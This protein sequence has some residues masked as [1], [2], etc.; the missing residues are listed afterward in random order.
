MIARIRQLVREHWSVLPN[1]GEKL[2]ESQL[3][4][5]KFCQRIVGHNTKILFLVTHASRTVCI[6]KIMRNTS[7]DWMLHREADAQRTLSSHHIVPQ[8]FFDNAVGQYLYAEEVIE[9]TPISTSVARR[10]APEII[11]SL[12]SLPRHQRVSAAEIAAVFAEYSTLHPRLP[13]YIEYVQH[14]G[15][16]ISKGLTHGDFG[17]PNIL[18]RD[19]VCIIDWGRSGDCPWYGIDA[20]QFYA[21]LHNISSIDGWGQ[22]ASRFTQLSGMDEKTSS[23]LFCLHTMYAILFKQYPDAYR[24]IVERFQV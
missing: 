14:S 7:Y 13:V 23:V 10:R 1:R 24:S 11:R 3:H 12:M 8:V 15:A 4:V 5:T 6:V 21:R 2:T 22:A 16:L 9:G 17:L 20:V 19:T 18:L